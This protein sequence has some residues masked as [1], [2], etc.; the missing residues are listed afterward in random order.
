VPG[1]AAFA[2]LG[3]LVAVPP[4]ASDAPGPAQAHVDVD[5]DVDV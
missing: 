2:R 3:F 5:V 4:A 1:R